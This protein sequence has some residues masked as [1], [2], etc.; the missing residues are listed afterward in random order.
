[1]VTSSGNRKFEPRSRWAA[2]GFDP[3][4][5]RF[6]RTANTRGWFNLVECRFRRRRG[7]PLRESRRSA[8]ER[9]SR[10]RYDRAESY[11]FLT[12]FPDHPQQWQGLHP[13][14]VPKGLALSCAYFSF[15]CDTY[16]S[17]VPDVNPF[18]FWSGHEIAWWRLGASMPRCSLRTA[19]GFH[20]W[21]AEQRGE[22]RAA[23]RI[24]P[25]A[26]FA[27][28]GSGLVA[29][30]AWRQPSPT[31]GSELANGS[32]E[33]R[34]DLE[35]PRQARWQGPCKRH[36]RRLPVRRRPREPPLKG[37]KQAEGKG[38]KCLEPPSAEPWGRQRPKRNERSSA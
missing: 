34:I 14:R 10:R 5:R 35:L 12:T 24:G 11:W 22:F 13:L 17:M 23:D 25:I 1:M 33:Q 21:L 27:R 2:G 36:G 37:S 9:P 7:W 31:R 28:E 18:W 8:D 4:S 16:W 38:S 26:L 3:I 6:V 30:R 20:I 32:V 15:T 19:G 29:A